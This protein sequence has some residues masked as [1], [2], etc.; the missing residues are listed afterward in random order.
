LRYQQYRPLARFG[1]FQR[2]DR[3]L[4]ADK[5]WIDLVRKDDQFP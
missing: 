4:A 2:L 1:R 3:L 5:Y